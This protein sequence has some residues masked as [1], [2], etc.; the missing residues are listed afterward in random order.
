[1]TES[2][3]RVT[4]SKS[5][6]GDSRLRSLS[7]AKIQLPAEI[8]NLILHEHNMQDNNTFHM[9]LQYKGKTNGNQE[10]V[11]N[12]QSTFVKKI[13]YSIK[14]LAECVRQH[15]W[16]DECYKAAVPL[17]RDE[18]YRLYQLYDAGTI[19]GKGYGL[20][21]QNDYPTLQRV[22]TEGLYTLA[23]QLR[24]L[25]KQNALSVL[26]AAFERVYANNNTMTLY[27]DSVVHKYFTECT[28]VFD[29]FKPTLDAKYN[30]IDQNQ[31]RGM[32]IYTV[33]ELVERMQWVKA[34]QK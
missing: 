31:E 15:T 6:T 25:S 17:S 26:D 10:I 4:D 27:I 33:L 14:T 9:Q 2:F 11:V 12:P 30:I 28:A 8:V 19:G 23:E 18:R 1:M 3:T 13:E 24:G 34:N 21:H 7:N 32:G 29:K 22:F 5:A 16:L 20:F